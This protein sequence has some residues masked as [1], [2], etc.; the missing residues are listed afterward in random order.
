M[1]PS[2]EQAPANIP[3]RP[4]NRFAQQSVPPPSRARL[5]A[6]L[7]DF[8]NSQEVYWSNLQ[9]ESGANSQVRAHAASFI[10][11]GGRILDVACGCAA[12][13]VPLLQRGKYFGTDI[14]QS[15]LRRARR[16]GLH[17]SCADAASLPFPDASFD[18]AIS[19]YSHEHSVN[20]AR[21]V[22]EIVRVVRPGG[23]IVLLGPT[24]DFPFWYPS[25]LL[26]RARNPFWRFGYTLK[27][28]SAQILAL[29]GGPSP[30]LI[31]E[32][33]DAFSQPFI[34]DSDAVYVVWSYEVFR[35]RA[36]ARRRGFASAR[37]EFHFQ[38]GQKHPPAFSS[39]PP[40]RQHRP[41][42]LPKILAIVLPHPPA[43]SANDLRI[44][45]SA[46]SFTQTLLEV[47]PSGRMF[48]A[49]TAKKL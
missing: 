40:R 24:W 1:E 49:Q 7:K 5:K 27:R 23:R 37:D 14:S 22:S 30:F 6:R 42:C 47:G 25:S 35:L 9:T 4:A 10:P 11:Q 18:A 13:S 33:P 20:P 43:K 41:L 39:L 31:V 28:L 15:G 38:T 45:A 3:S 29:L 19:T 8:W 36:R 32:E 34:H 46:R 48:G 26:T 44:R 16:P 17:L 2:R 21:M 12:N